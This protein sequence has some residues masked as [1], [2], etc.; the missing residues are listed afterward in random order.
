M[1]AAFG[2][3]AGSASQVNGYDFFRSKYNI[4]IHRSIIDSTVN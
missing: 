2:T 1:S 4:Q 3:T